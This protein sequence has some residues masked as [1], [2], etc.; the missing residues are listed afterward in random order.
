MGRLNANLCVLGTLVAIA[1]GSPAQAPDKPRPP[2]P[3]VAA[4]EGPD[5]VVLK[6]GD[7]HL[8][9]LMVTAFRIRADWG[10]LVLPKQAVAQVLI[11]RG[12][13]GADVLTTGDGDRITGRV[14]GRYVQVARTS[15]VPLD[16]NMKDI[17]EIT[18][19]P[20]PEVLRPLPA[21]VLALRN[22]D[23]LRVDVA[24]SRLTID[25]GAGKTTLAPADLRLMDI[26]PLDTGT[27]VRAVLRQDE[28]RI[29]GRLLEADISVV[30]RAGQELAVPVAQL[31]GL[32]GALP[33]AA[34]TVEHLATPVFQP[35][36]RPKLR[37]DRL[38]GGGLGPE[39]VE[40][41]PGS[42]R[43]GDLQ[44]EGDADEAPVREVR[45]AKGFAIGRYPV[46]FEEYDLFCERTG[47]PKPD[48]AGW[49]RG[50]RPVVNVNWYEAS[51]YA[52]WLSQQ[53]G[54]RYRLPSNAEFEYAAR[55]GSATRYPWGDEPGRDRAACSGCGSLW[56]GL[57]SAP[58]GRFAPNGFGLYDMAGNVWQWT[59]DCWDADYKSAPVDGA[60]HTVAGYCDKKVVRGGSWGFP[61]RELRSANR[62]RDFTVRPSDDTGLRVVRQL[63]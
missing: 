54:K 34:G 26:E 32:L 17:A 55:G 48:D 58:V 39:M 36:P 25:T 29:Q 1:G 16:I 4:R 47:R 41:A 12:P 37:R 7:D 24:T 53:T 20:R 40:L 11:G 23:A 45:I 5:F 63:D 57:R 38:R 43:R 10:D 44:G 61:A 33:V 6:N 27:R 30:T 49:G 46:T 50:R 62:W 15:Y 3:G 8:G 56:D 13:G 18:L 60:A 51:A 59:Q 2:V 35:W 9:R 52:E 22:G 19:T 42:F 31:S 21:F 28:R 14:E